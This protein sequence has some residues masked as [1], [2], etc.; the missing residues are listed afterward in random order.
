M[1]GPDCSG[2]TTILDPYI[3]VTSLL[4]S[5]FTVARNL[6]I[7][8]QLSPYARLPPSMLYMAKPTS[9]MLKMLSPLVSKCTAAY[10][11]STPSPKYA[12][13][14]YTYY[15]VALA[16]PV[17]TASIS[18]SVHLVL[19]NLAGSSLRSKYC[20]LGASTLPRDWPECPPMAPYAS[21]EDADEVVLAEDEGEAG[22]E[23][24]E[25]ERWP[26]GP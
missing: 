20:P 25:R 17:S 8:V 5:L 18:A 15:A 2:E 26:S 14:L 3:L 13:L 24:E 23:V 19:P 7:E 9:P 22:D 21:T 4:R 11:K 1:T 6:L 12:L 16:P 10:R